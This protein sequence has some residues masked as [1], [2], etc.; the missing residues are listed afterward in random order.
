MGI[1]PWFDITMGKVLAVRVGQSFEHLVSYDTDIRLGHWSGL[2]H[3]L[4][5]VTQG[6][7]FH[8]DKDMVIGIVPP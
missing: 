7:V 2:D 4:L 3:V 6:Q 8:Y 5:E 1:Y